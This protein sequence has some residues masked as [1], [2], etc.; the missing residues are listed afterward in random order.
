LQDK[1]QPK[2]LKLLK[3]IAQRLGSAPSVDLEGRQAILG[4]APVGDAAQIGGIPTLAAAQMQAVTGQARKTGSSRYGC[5][6]CGLCRQQ[7]QRQFLMIL[8]A[9]EAQLDTAPVER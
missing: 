6:C 2:L 5:C 7:L 8:Q 3:S 1:E 4:T 9:V